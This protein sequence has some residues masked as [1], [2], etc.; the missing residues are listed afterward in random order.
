VGEGGDQVSVARFIAA[1]RTEHRVPHTVACRALG[2]SPSWFYKWQDRAPTPRRRRH[3][4]L[5]ERI[6]KSFTDSGG[7]YGSP[8]V[9]LDL[10]DEGER[11]SV[12]TVAKIMR[13]ECLVARPKKRPHSLTRQGKRAAPTD[14]VRRQFNAVAANVLWTGDLTEIRTGE[15]KLY[16]ATV[17]DM[18][19]RNALGHAFSAHHDA[20]LAVAALQMAATRRGGDI[21]GVIF[22]SDR[23][24]EGEFNRSSQHLEFGGVDGQ[25]GG[26]D[27]GVDGQVGDEVAWGAVT[28]ARC[29]AR[30]LA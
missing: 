27:E 24:S 3:Q 16:L 19:S 23:G 6:N 28:S 9:V 15:G 13:R 18:F 21:D 14:K 17:L 30:V 8:R 7:T 4:E 12:N 2:V 10:R 5:T 22:H 25:A 11:V 26:V 20:D 29:R 1:Q